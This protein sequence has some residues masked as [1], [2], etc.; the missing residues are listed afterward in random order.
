MNS[1][2]IFDDIWLSYQTMLDSLKI[3]S[4]TIRKD[5]IHER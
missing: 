3:T 5:V 2:N 1:K 4:Y